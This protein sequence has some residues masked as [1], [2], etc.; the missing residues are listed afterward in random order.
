Y[1]DVSI[2]DNGTIRTRFNRYGIQLPVLATIDN[3]VGVDGMIAYSTSE[4][5]S[6]QKV[7]GQWVPIGSGSVRTDEFTISSWVLSGNSY[8]LTVTASNIVTAEIQEQVSPG[9]YTRVEV[10]SVTFNGTNVVFS[11]PSTPDVR[12]DGRTLVTIR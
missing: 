11:I 6:M 9:V 12:F 10:D 4:R 7:K 1:A 5:T 8:T 3:S 2:Y